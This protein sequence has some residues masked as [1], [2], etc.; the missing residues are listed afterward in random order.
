MNDEARG[1]SRIES[2]LFRRAARHEAVSRR[3]FSLVYFATAV[4][5][6]CAAWRAFRSD[7]GAMTLLVGTALLL[8]AKAGADLEGSFWESIVVKM[9]QERA[10]LLAGGR[11]PDAERSANER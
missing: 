3:I 11:R 4:I 8:A 2:W 1:F 9:K 6:V 5:S 7:P 10:A